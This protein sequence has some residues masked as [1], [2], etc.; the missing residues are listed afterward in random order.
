MDTIAFR[1]PY[2]WGKGSRYEYFIKRR[3]GG[4]HLS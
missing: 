4:L 1:L 3:L 2:L